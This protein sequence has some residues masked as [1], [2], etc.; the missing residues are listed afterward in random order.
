MNLYEE[1]KSTSKGNY[2]GKCKRQ[3]E[4]SGCNFFLLTDLKGHI[5]IILNLYWWIYNVYKDL[6]CMITAQKSGEESNGTILQQSFYK[7]LKV[8]WHKSKIMN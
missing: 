3:Y 2:T 1:I 5:T 7:Q 6:I 8:S 4:I